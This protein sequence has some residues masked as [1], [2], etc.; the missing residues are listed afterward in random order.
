M[1]AGEGMS[2]VKLGA[3]KLPF[4]AGS[5]CKFVYQSAQSCCHRAVCPV[6]GNVLS[7]AEPQ[8]S[9]AGRKSRSEM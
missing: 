1:Q 3:R 6:S 4:G 9:A 2:I 5:V 8:G 7:A